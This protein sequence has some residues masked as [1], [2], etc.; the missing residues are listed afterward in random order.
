MKTI[1]EIYGD[2]MTPALASTILSSANSCLELLIPRRHT[3][4]HAD[5]HDPRID[6]VQDAIKFWSAI[7]DQYTMYL[8]DLK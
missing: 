5:L 7:R 6:A 2:L 1:N 3:L 4:V 8:K